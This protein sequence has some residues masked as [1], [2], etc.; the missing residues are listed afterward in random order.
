LR[1]FTSDELRR[2]TVRSATIGVFCI[3]ST[4]LVALTAVPL[5]GQT[6]S[7]PDADPVTG[8]E[9]QPPPSAPTGGGT[10]IDHNQPEPQNSEA[11]EQGGTTGSRP[12]NHMFGVLPNYSTVE[13]ATDITAVGARAKLTMASLNTFDPYVYPFV[14]FQATLNHTYGSGA[15]GYLKQYVASLTDN[16]TGNFLTTAV[17]PSILHQDPR[18]FERGSGSVL[19]RV[20][21]AASRSVVT[22]SDAGQLQFNLSE[23]GGNAIAAGISNLYY[24]AAEHSVTGTLTRWGMQVMWDTLS[25][26][27]KEFWPDVRRKLH[28]Q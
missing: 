13:N 20:A 7:P 1:P 6:L 26:E 21:Y 12:G 23:I 17:L 9:S 22:R 24:P 4:L 27:L 2:T 18:Y 10:A 16:A 3:A 28:G 25:N 19:S 15:S 5:R 14:G 8:P 11:V